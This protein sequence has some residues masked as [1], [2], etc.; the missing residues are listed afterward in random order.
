MQTIEVS[1]ADF[2]RLQ[3]VADSLVG[4]TFRTAIPEL[5]A[6]VS[7]IAIATAV[8][9]VLDDYEARSGAIPA[10]S[11]R[12]NGSRKLTYDETNIPEMRHT[13][14]LSCRF[15]NVT[16]E[17]TTWDAMVSLALVAVHASVGDV[18]SLRRIA[19]A[20][21]VSGKKD[22]EGYKYLPKQGFSYQGVSA[23]DAVEIIR[24][25]AKA[26][27]CGAYIEFEWRSKKD[28]LHPGERAVLT[29]N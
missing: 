21:V 10:P 5:R 11:G 9:R 8:S 18:G 24:R 25:S 13:K 29:I 6:E 26:L 15:D 23:T 4:T 2:K 17:K 14:L 1:D 16:P 12:P 27:H 22:S 7:K 20:N 19:G 28:A 3:N